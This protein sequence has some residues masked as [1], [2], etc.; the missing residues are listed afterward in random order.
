MPV[1]PAVPG[2][3]LPVVPVGLPCV[4]PL[5]PEPPLVEPVAELP[6]PLPLVPDGLQAVKDSAI[7]P[8]TRRLRPVLIIISL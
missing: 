6:P 7:M 1:E 3:A 2:W 5:V 8:V 4:V